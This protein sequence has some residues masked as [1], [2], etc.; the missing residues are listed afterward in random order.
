MR[1]LIFLFYLI[2][3]SLFLGETYAQ[4]NNKSLITTQ[5]VKNFRK[6]KF[7]YSNKELTKEESSVIFDRGKA[8]ALIAII[9][10]RA[11]INNFNGDLAYVH[12]EILGKSQITYL[13]EWIKTPYANRAIDIVS[14]YFDSECKTS[15]ENYQ[16][17]DY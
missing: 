14:E 17:I 10:C 4:L 3:P 6:P 15:E 2:I 13:E 9:N 11:K 8:V 12:R 1:V 5:Q 16:K 7:V